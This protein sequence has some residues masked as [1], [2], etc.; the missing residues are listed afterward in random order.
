MDNKGIRTVA[1]IVASFLAVSAEVIQFKDC[2]PS[3]GVT[4]HATSVELSPCTS[5]PCNFKHGQTVNVKIT[6]TANNDTPTLKSTV[7]GIVFNV[8][9][10]FPLPNADA[11]SNSGLTC[12]IQKGQTYTYSSS[13]DVKDSYPQIELVVM[14][15]LQGA[16]S[17]EVCFTFPD[18]HQ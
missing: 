4:G 15:K 1:L 12:P 17:N 10:E 11:C 5:Q 18:V 3:E 14:W 16:S 9:V 7:Y 13:F 8:P 2:L 6:F